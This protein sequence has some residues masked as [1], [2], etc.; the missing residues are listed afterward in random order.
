[1]NKL[2]SE[3]EKLLDFF[4]LDSEVAN[5]E[6]EHLETITTKIK[7]AFF[8]NVQGNYK[9]SLDYC[10]EVY[11]E[12][13]ERSI[14]SQN[15]KLK[16]YVT[17]IRYSNL[18]LED[19][20]E[21]KSFLKNKLF[22]IIEYEYDKT[23]DIFYLDIGIHL[24][25]FII[26]TLIDRDQ[27]EL[28]LEFFKKL[29]QLIKILLSDNQF[30]NQKISIIQDCIN[31]LAYIRNS[32]DNDA[33]FNQTI[34]LTNL[35]LKDLI[36]N[37][38]CTVELFLDNLTFSNEADYYFDHNQLDLAY[39]LSDLAIKF[40]NKYQEKN[41]HILIE[42]ELARNYI[43]QGVIFKRKENIE[44]SINSLIKGINY[45]SKRSLNQYETIQANNLISANLFLADNYFEIENYDK[46][47]KHLQQNLDLISQFDINYEFYENNVYT[48]L[49]LIKIAIQEKK[50]IEIEKYFNEFLK[51]IKTEYLQFVTFEECIYVSCEILFLL[52]EAQILTEK[53]YNNFVNRIYNN[54]D[55]IGIF[56]Q[57]DN[58]DH[59]LKTRLFELASNKLMTYTYSLIPRKIYTRVTKMTENL[60]KEDPENEDLIKTQEMLKLL[61]LN[62]EIEYGHKSS[63]TKK[64]RIYKKK[65]KKN[66]KNRRK[67]KKRKK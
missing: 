9:K 55:K 48:L 14:P 35:I 62:N 64:K 31:S 33:I 39:E 51:L 52:S 40:L 36:D 46:A 38:I 18:I 37:P 49:F 24:L 41:T 60:L 17:V 67:K 4:K 63:F 1:M 23:Q 21:D 42:N 15:K 34:E 2:Y 16:F 32:L 54:L 29:K 50:I 20:K 22:K 12:L 13:K 28:S 19:N 66:L 58:C 6:I 25:F 26:Q 56:D 3:I 47:L 11:Q 59:N 61:E 45:L 43:L 8:E 44:Q 30:N 53:E 7:T 10:N 57:F 5:E 27:I 65:N